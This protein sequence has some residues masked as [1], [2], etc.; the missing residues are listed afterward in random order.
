MELVVIAGPY[1]LSTVPIVKNAVIGFDGYRDG[2][3]TY[4]PQVP[5]RNDAQAT[6]AI[7]TIVSQI[8]PKT[9]LPC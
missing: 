3:E 6:T 2:A 7:W 9:P 5:T 4:F 8:N 1:E